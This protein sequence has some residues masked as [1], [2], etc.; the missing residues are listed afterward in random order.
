MLDNSNGFALGES[1][2]IQ[3]YLVEKYGKTDSL[4]PKAAEKRG[5]INQR[6]IFDQCTLY[7]PIYAYYMSKFYKKP[8]NPEHMQSIDKAFSVLDKFLDGKQYVAGN[9]MSLADISTYVSVSCMEVIG[10]D[11][12]NYANVN[13]WYWMMDESRPSRLEDE[14]LLNTYETWIKKAM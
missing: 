12:K 14:L 1:R 2:A 3:I 10:Y 8:E 9:E 7:H 13:K 4:Y 11:L 5:T 6:L